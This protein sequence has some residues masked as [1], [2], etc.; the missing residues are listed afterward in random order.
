MS[1]QFRGDVKY[2]GEV[3]IKQEQVEVTRVTADSISCLISDERDYETYLYREEKGLKLNCE[4]EQATR[5]GGKCKHTWA[6]IL[7]VDEEELLSG[8]CKEGYIPPFITEDSQPLA[9]DDE[10][11]AING[12]VDFRRE[13]YGKSSTQAS[14]I[15]KRLKPWEAALQHVREHLEKDRQISMSASKEREIYYEIDKDR[16]QEAKEIILQLMQRQR[17]TNGQWGKHKPFKLRAGHEQNLQQ[18]DSQI[19]VYLAGGTAERSLWYSQDLSAPA[20]D[21]FRLPFDLCEL[22]LPQMCA[23]GRCQLV[24]KGYSKPVPLLWSEDEPWE[25]RIRV[26]EIDTIPTE[27][28]EDQIVDEES[29]DA[30]EKE[31]ENE[32]N[33]ETEPS[34]S[35]KGWKISGDLVKADETI[36]LNEADLLVAGGLIVQRG[37]ICRL[38]EFGV[39]EWVPILLA[40]DALTI[41]EEDE[42]AWVENLFSLST[43]PRLELPEKLRLEEVQG[44]PKPH[45][46][47]QTPKGRRWHPDRIR[48]ELYFDYLG[49]LVPSND[50]TP[51]VIQR[52]QNRCVNRNREAEVAAWQMLREMGFRVIQDPRHHSM[53]V[54]IPARQLG[55]TLGQLIQNQW[56]VQ[57]D[58]KNV[59]QNGEMA[60]RVQSGIDWFE[61]HARVAFEGQAVSFPQLLQALARGETTIRLEDGSL[62]IVPED[63]A[64]R[65]GLLAGLGDLEEDHIR[66]GNNQVLMLDALLASQSGIDYDKKY[67]KL[68]EK[69]RAFDGVACKHELKNFHGELREYQREGLGWLNFLQEFEFGGCLAD[70][71]GLGKTV[72]L[73]ALLQERKAERKKHHPTLIVVPKSIV[74]NWVQECERFTPNLNSLEYIGMDRATLRPKFSNHDLIFTT[75]GTLRRDVIELKDILFDYIVLDEAQTIKNAASQTAKASRLLQANHRLAL[76]GTPIE[77]HLGDLWSI[78][79]FLNPGMLG[80]SSTFKS[81]LANADDEEAQRLLSEGLS[82]FIL[83]RTKKQVA[84]ELP[85]KI[86]QTI[87]CPM[88]EEQQRLYN[89]LRDHYRMSLM[90]IVQEQGL[91]K[92]KMHVLEALLRLR[93]AACHPAL[94]KKGAEEDMSAKLEVLIPHLQE[95]INEN[96]KVLV[97]SQFT[98][99]LSIVKT[100][101]NQTD[102]TYE[103]LDGKTRHRQQCVE[104]FQTDPDCGIFLI[105][106]K[107]G[108]LG[109]N[110]TAADYVFLL[111]PWWNPAVETQAIDRAHRV[112]Q[113][114]KV[115]AYRLICSGTV[116]EKIAELQKKKKNLAEAILQADSNLL[117]NLSSSDLQMLLS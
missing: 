68:R 17:R 14:A 49:T 60:F 55:N 2:R 108:G 99:M 24:G 30:K 42:D 32:E 102:L 84:H 80:R 116:E 7:S 114:R 67:T 9:F 5:Q 70:D 3:Y 53:A 21:S 104:R 33:N 11:W 86:E 18:E 100:H 1:G 89:Q 43:L 78:F 46:R 117:K 64:N 69:F 4:C 110:L 106:L 96:H 111:D 28:I 61:L 101:L 52:E 8:S 71:M 47:I 16:S 50:K 38:V 45:L 79:E 44:D 103:Y 63:W 115:I 15:K 87:Y 57:A 73:L 95:L 92:S 62:G 83:R 65:Y 72:Q 12:D 41:P 56:Q 39:F 107:A 13:S 51:T 90:G 82:P 74:F 88:R 94:L 91:A 54:E 97:F 23:T 58:D 20:T 19:L 113:T 36:S 34:P 31:K 22:V 35:K 66:F 59:R 105:S 26:D 25:L 48:G 75:Y 29:N 6:T 98:S 85:E 10:E 109:L 93:Q 76:S 27:L 37:K 77:N 112:G 40:E 81:Y